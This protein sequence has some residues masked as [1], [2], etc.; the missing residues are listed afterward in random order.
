MWYPRSIGVVAVVLGSL[1]AIAALSFS[2]QAQTSGVTARLRGV[3]AVSNDVAWTSGAHGTI[4]R[5]SDGG[6]TWT[7]RPIPGA[8]AFDFRDVDALDARTAVALSIGAGDASRIYRTEDAGATWRAVFVN[9]EPKAFFDAVA[10]VDGVHG[11]AVSDSVDGRFVVIVT[12][13]GGRTWTSVDPEALP[14]ALPGEGAFAASGSNIAVRG[15]DVWIGTGAGAR[16]RVLHST[17]RG[18]HWTVADTPLPAGPSAGI[19][20]IAFRDTR[21]GVVVGGDYRKEGEATDNV[22]VTS[23]GGATWSLGHRLSGFR[24]AVAY[25]PRH[26]A[27]LLAVGPTGADVSTDEG[28]TWSAVPNASGADALSFARGAAVG[29]AT[30]DRGT[31]VRLSVR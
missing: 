26:P 17:D 30:G 12:G 19:F 29:W 18:R 7:P 22:A 3:S 1:T 5:T 28:Q 25:V 13:D 31:I 9:R 16:A 24:S 23:D 15:T 11:V 10:F 14:P 27:T 4:L 6:A 21:H 8:E 2:W 20:S